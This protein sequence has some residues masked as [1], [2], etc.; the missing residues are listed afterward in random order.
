MRAPYYN[1]YFTLLFLSYCFA[2]PFLIYKGTIAYK[3]NKSA[4]CYIAL[5]V[6]AIA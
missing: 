5:R 1:Y 4:S 2:Y 3:I 6:K